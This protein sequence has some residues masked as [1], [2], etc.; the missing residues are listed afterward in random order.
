MLNHDLGASSRAAL[1]RAN[2]AK[3]AST[4][5][6][7][8]R[9]AK[10]KTKTFHENIIIIIPDKQLPLLKSSV[11]WK[12]LFFQNMIRSCHLKDNVFTHCQWS[13]NEMKLG[14]IWKKTSCSQT[15]S[16]W[17]S[18][19]SLVTG[20]NLNLSWQES[21]ALLLLFYYSAILS[22]ML[23][24]SF[25]EIYLLY[26]PR[27]YPTNTLLFSN[28]LLQAEIYSMISTISTISIDGRKITQSVIIMFW[29]RNIK[30]VLPKL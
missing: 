4:A 3:V 22:A 9:S 13:S 2:L 5:Q 8:E 12:Y 1:I 18:W 24:F 25:L 6:G 19:V 29:Q 7:E 27:Y 10:L 16:A 14:Q 17:C 23:L 21:P 20:C 28:V 26:N 30:C 15:G 11:G